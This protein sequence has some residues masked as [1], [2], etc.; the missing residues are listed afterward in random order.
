MMP[1]ISRTGQQWQQGLQSFVTMIQMTVEPNLV[2]YNVTVWEDSV[3]VFLSLVFGC[4]F[5][6]GFWRVRRMHKFGEVAGCEL[7]HHG[8]PKKM[9]CDALET[10]TTTPFLPSTK[11]CWRKK[12]RGFWSFNSSPP[13]SWCVW[14]DT[15]FFFPVGFLLNGFLFKQKTDGNKKNM[16]KVCSCCDFFY[17]ETYCRFFLLMSYVFLLFVK[18]GV[19]DPWTKKTPH[20]SNS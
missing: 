20:A 16:D 2:A 5:F 8:S 15:L 9:G 11:I 1:F 12:P 4:W 17:C 10:Y 6:V 18:V 19:V 7:K 14:K 13:S 3:R